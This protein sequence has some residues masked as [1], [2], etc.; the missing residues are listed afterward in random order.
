MN[1]K[2]ISSRRRARPSAKRVML[3]ALP[4]A[5]A[6]ASL[7]NAAPI[8]TGNPDLTV[9]FDNTLKYSAAWRMKG[10][11]DVFL[12]NLNGDDGDRNFRKGLIS[13]RVD[14]LSEL[15][16]NYRDFGLRVSG[17][18]WY[19]NV[20]NR[21]NDNNSPATFNPISVRNTEFTS[22]TEKLMG[23]KAEILDAFVFG[24]QSFGEMA[25]SFRAGQH[26]LLWG[27][28][29]L[30]P[31][32]GISYGQAPL[33]IIKAAAVPSSLAKEVFLPIGQVS[34]QLQARENLSFAGYYQYDWQKSRIPAAGSFFSPGDVADDGGERILL[35]P[36]P[37]PAFF[38][39]PDLSAKKSG[40]W[41][42]GVRY[43]ASTDLELG[44]YYLN[45]HDKLPQAYLRPGAAVTPLGLVVL[46][47]V[48]FNPAIGKFGEY[49]LVYPEDIRVVGGS[50]STT[51]L[52]ANMA[53]EVSYRR[54]APLVS[55]PQVILPGTPL[56]QSNPLYAVG[57]TSHAQVSVL[58]VFNATPIWN[59]ANL[60]AEIAWNRTNKI[61]KNAAALD[62][63]A[64]RDAWGVRVAFE[65]FYNNVLPGLNLSIPLFIGYTEGRSS[66]VVGFGNHR[67]GN[68]SVG[69]SGTYLNVW[70]FGLTYTGFYGSAGVDGTRPGDQNLRDRDFVSFNVRRTF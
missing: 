48:L 23:R 5:I 42:V 52:S 1:A 14:L 39:A 36:N 27:E 15:D 26:T 10:Q 70:K 22:A 31:T 53:G 17:A 67:G 55:S 45:Y 56:S 38:R 62:P 47:P 6:W 54:N 40:Q 8:E 29:L 50:F 30:F 63:N 35:G 44:L 51:L 37:G 46:D 16:V 41:G 28:S 61:T 24:K 57:E 33:D 2:A 7:T 13:N 12:N 66:A 3:G 68:Y 49:L 34:G 20:Y 69:L 60:A 18:A 32:N 65:P 11:S 59:S 58:Q 25:A 19:D 9:R 43:A 21:S 64:D 4:A